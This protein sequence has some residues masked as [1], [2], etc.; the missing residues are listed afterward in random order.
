MK[1]R[2][3]YQVKNDLN[4]QSYARTSDCGH[5]ANIFFFFERLQFGGIEKV[6]L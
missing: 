2:I 6:I 5:Y 1:Y 4:L 3:K